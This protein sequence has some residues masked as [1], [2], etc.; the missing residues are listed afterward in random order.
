MSTITDQDLDHWF[1][2]HPPRDGQR[3]RYESIRAQAKMF[4][5]VVLEMTGP[6]ADQTAAL[7]KIREA[8]MTANA[9]IALEGTIQT[10]YYAQKFRK[11]EGE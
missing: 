3:E 4:A 8:V 2:Y 9:A 5:R 10:L 1:S 7:R 11:K 6:G